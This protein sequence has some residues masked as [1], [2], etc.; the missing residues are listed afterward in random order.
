METAYFQ[1]LLNVCAA[2]VQ[3]FEFLFCLAE[4]GEGGE[5]GGKRGEGLLTAQGSGEGR[6]RDGKFNFGFYGSTNRAERDWK[7]GNFK[8]KTLQVYK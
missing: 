3:T 1:L 4:E 8:F 5:E 2:A 7:Y 6:E